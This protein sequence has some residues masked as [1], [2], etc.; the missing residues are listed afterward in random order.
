MISR[1][2]YIRIVSAA[3][4]ELNSGTEFESILLMLKENGFS[5]IDCIRG[6]IDLTGS[7]MT[8]A[9][10]RVHFSRAWAATREQSDELHESLESGLAEEETS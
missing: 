10:E 5:Q 9:K 6:T 1:Q 2:D 8:E 3:R 4:A 7:S